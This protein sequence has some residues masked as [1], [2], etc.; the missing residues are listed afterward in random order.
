MDDRNE[1]GTRQL[2]LAPVADRDLGRAF[3]I[4]AAV[5]GRER[6]RRQVDHL[7]ARLDAADAGAPA[8]FLE[9]AVDVDRHRVGGVHPGVFL[10]LVAVG[11]LLERERLDRL[12]FRAVRQTR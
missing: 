11:V 6:M 3:E 2:V 1:A 7:A 10:A 9:R 12:G 5:V 8:P 4:D